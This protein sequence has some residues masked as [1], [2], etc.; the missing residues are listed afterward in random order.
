MAEAIYFL[1]IDGGGS[2]CRARLESADGRLL[3]HGLGGPANPG[4]GLERAMGSIREA[5]GAA[6]AEAGLAPEAMRS[7]HAGAGIAGLHLPR[8]RHAVDRAPHPFRSLAVDDDLR[9]ACLAAHGGGDG[10][11]IIAGT[12]FS[13]LSM[14]GGETRNIG[15]YGFMLGERCSGARIGFSAVNAALLACDGLGPETLLGELLRRELGGAGMQLADAL[16]GATAD[17]YAALAP[18]VFEAAQ[19]GDVVAGH[20]LEE[21][22]AFIGDV[23]A[24]LLKEQPPRL[25]LVGGIGERIVPWL[26]ADIARQLAPPKASAE[27]GAIRLAREQFQS[28]REQQ[29]S[30]GEVSL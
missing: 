28:T 18:R 11:V 22:A 23:A 17:K 19:W 24:I 9:I 2:R 12:G 27:V 7:I 10:A 16:A 4:Y 25:S 30:T 6:L 3:G 5:A 1:G 8:H 20:I 21:C 15:G 14:I 13:A 26:A 29:L